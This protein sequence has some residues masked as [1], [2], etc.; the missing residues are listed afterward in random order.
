MRVEPQG[1]LKKV[2][3]ASKAR[4]DRNGASGSIGLFTDEFEQQPGPSTS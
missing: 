3:K 2:V 4:Y 1:K